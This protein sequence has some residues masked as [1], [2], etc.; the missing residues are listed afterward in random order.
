MRNIRLA[1][2]RLLLRLSVVFVIRVAALVASFNWR[3]L[4]YRISAACLGALGLLG[5]EGNGKSHA[6]LSVPMLHF[7]EM[8]RSASKVQAWFDH[9]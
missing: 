3:S 4:Q 8:S 7:S 6:R 1:I 9:S 5:G 2:C